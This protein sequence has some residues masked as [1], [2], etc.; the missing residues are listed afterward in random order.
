MPARK[1]LESELQATLL[2]ASHSPLNYCHARKPAR[3]DEIEQVY[4]ERRAS[5]QAFDPELV[6][7]FGSDHFNGFFMKLMP[8][9]CIGA[10][11]HAAADI[12]GF[13]GPLEVP[14]ETALECVRALRQS[15]LDPAVSY[16][17]TVDHAFSQTLTRALGGLDR[18]PTI[19]VFINCV[20]E[21]FVPFRRTRLLGEAIGRFTATLGRRVLFLASGGMSHHPTRYYPDFGTG[22]ESVTAWQLSGG[23]RP[24]SL[25]EV[26]WLERLEVMHR[27]GAQMIVDGSRT[28]EQMRLNPELDKRFLGVLTGGDLTAFDEWDQRQAVEEGGIGFMELQTWIAAAAAYRAGVGGRPVVDL[29]GVT[30]EL[31]IATGIVHGD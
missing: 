24:E 28:P 3:W 2:C 31:G 5:L 15:G 20:T 10:A 26:E 6:I 13:A 11:A 29:Y 18:Y 4:R 23:S 17:M 8:A 27:E 14:G 16:D 19:P 9:F 21:P 7:A 1:E 22:E 25:N 12:G 30:E